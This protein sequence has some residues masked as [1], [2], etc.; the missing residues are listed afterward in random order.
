MK[1]VNKMS[2]EL[3]K[4]L[5]VWRALCHLSKPGRVKYC[6]TLGR[7]FC[8]SFE[9]EL[10]QVYGREIPVI[11]REEVGYYIH[12]GHRPASASRSRSADTYFLFDYEFTQG[13]WFYILDYSE[14]EQL[15]HILRWGRDSYSSTP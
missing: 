7:D 9:T 2:I 3:D 4:F 10:I 11:F 1:T 5:A 14:E 8:E 12:S 15:E 6:R 13:E